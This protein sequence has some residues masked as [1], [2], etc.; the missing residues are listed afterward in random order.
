MRVEER[1]TRTIHT[2]REGD[3]LLVAA[4][5]LWDHDCGALPVVDDRGQVR[6]MLTDRDICMAAYTTGKRLQDLKVVDAM[7]KNVA[8]LRPAESLQEAEMVMRAR[9]VRRLPVLDD[10]HRLIGLLTC[11]DLCR[12]VDGG[13]ANGSTQH[14]AM[15]LLHTL[16]ALGSP[17]TKA[18]GVTGLRPVVLRAEDRLLGATARHPGQL[19]VSQVG[20]VRMPSPMK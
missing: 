9:S 2:C 6:G 16:A 11:N 4:Q 14:D 15:H 19:P 7:A 17:R 5:G 13:G 18:S 8:S 20:A 3:T 10:Q 12:W 1:M